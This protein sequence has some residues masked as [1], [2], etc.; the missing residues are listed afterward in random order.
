[1]QFVGAFGSLS[2]FKHM[3]RFA[4]CASPFGGV[5]ADD[6]AEG[7]ALGTG[8][9]RCDPVAREGLE[10]LVCSRVRL[11][12]STRYAAFGEV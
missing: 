5:I 10:Q 8:A 4:K 1:V 3:R 9:Q 12:G 2:G 6:C 11:D 7:V